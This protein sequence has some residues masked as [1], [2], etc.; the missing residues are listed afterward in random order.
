MN[1]YCPEWKPLYLSFFFQFFF[2][3]IATNQ[4]FIL[5]NDALFILFGVFKLNVSM[6][7]ITV[8]VSQAGQTI[9]NAFPAINPPPLKY[10]VP[11]VWYLNISPPPPV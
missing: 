9:R 4:V 3:K 10:K 11:L 6:R 5:L 7:L 2:V 1:F 8:S